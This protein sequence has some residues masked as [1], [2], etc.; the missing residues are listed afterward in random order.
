MSNLLL[1]EGQDD[2][3]VIKNLWKTYAKTTDLPFEIESLKAD[4]ELLAKFKEVVHDGIDD[5]QRIGIVID[6]DNKLDSRWE[7]FRH[8]L[9][10]AG[11]S[12]KLIPPKPL[13]EGTI[14]SQDNNGWFKQVGIWLM[15]NNEVPGNLEDF[16]S[17]LI[18]EEDRLWVYSAACL[19]GMPPSEGRFEEKDRAKARIHTWLAWQ[20]KPGTPLGQAITARYLSAQ[21]SHAQ[22]F[23]AWLEKL[24]ELA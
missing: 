16:A 19:A 3:H 13:P 15:P 7:S 8:S 20:K 11:Y 4:N 12:K 2:E 18:P 21:T 24:F 1:V 14:V 5:I 9:L 22:R 6:A 23:I 10:R 17:F